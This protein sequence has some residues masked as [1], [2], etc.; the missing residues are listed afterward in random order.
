MPSCTD[1]LTSHEAVQASED[2]EPQQPRLSMLIWQILCC[3]C[4]VQFRMIARSTIAC[5]VMV[6][7]AWHDDIPVYCR[8]HVATWRQMLIIETFAVG[9]LAAKREGGAQ[10][11]AAGAVVGALPVLL[12]LKRTGSRRDTRTTR[13]TRMLARTVALVVKVGHGSSNLTVALILTA[14]LR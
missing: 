11:L 4:V 9:E 7:T 8:R 12:Q 14:I 13:Q 6:F 10:K 3:C 1:E 2:D 5:L